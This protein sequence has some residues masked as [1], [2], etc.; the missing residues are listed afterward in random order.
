[1]A[2]VESAAAYLGMQV[3]DT[4][5]GQIIQTGTA[6]GRA[7]IKGDPERVA[8]QV[9]LAR[10][11]RRFA[12]VY[13][14]WH[15]SLFDASFLERE[16]APILARA[17]GR[18]DDASAA[19][20][21]A[22][23][24][25]QIGGETGERHREELEP[26]SALFLQAWREELEQQEV[27]R[28]VL[29]SQALERGADASEAVVQE[30]AALRVELADALGSLE[31]TILNRRRPDLAL[32]LDW[33][34]RDA[35]RRPSDFVG[36]EW[37]FEDLED[38]ARRHGRGYIHVVAEAGLGK[39]SLALETAR[40]LRA[41]AF[42]YRA[43][44]GRT[45]PAKCL[46]H[47]AVQLIAEHRLD[48][49]ELPLL[50]GSDSGFLVRILGELPLT[51]P[52]W[53]VIDALDEAEGALGAGANPSL[54][55]PDLPAGVF[56]LLTHR[57]EPLDLEVE[58][59]VGQ[60]TLRFRPGDA[61][62]E[63]DIRRYV[64]GRLGDPLIAAAVAR[65][66]HPAGG[67][68]I[69]ERLVTASEGNFK[70]LEYVFADI[71]SADA[72]FDL[73]VPPQGLDGYYRS[74]WKTMIERAGS[75]WDEIDLPLIEMLAVAGEA[76]TPEWLTDVTGLSKLQVR[77][78]LRR[79]Q[80]F[81]HQPDPENW[82][83]VHESFRDFLATT[84]D[85]DLPTAH[86]TLADLCLENPDDDYALAHT[87]V[88]LR[89]AERIAAL[90]ALVDGPSWQMAKLAADPSGAALLADITNAWDA[91]AEADRAA[92]RAER[93]PPWLLAEVVCAVRTAE[94]RSISGRVPAAL[95]ARLLED[96]V[97]SADEALAAAQLVPDPSERVA[98]LAAIAPHLPSGLRWR[99]ITRALD[100]AEGSGRG[101]EPLLRAIARIA[102][103]LTV[104]HRSSALQRALALSSA[105]VTILRD[106]LTPEDHAIV[107]AAL[108]KPTGIPAWDAHRIADLAPVLSP[109]DVRDALD[110]LD[111]LLPD[112]RIWAQALALAARPGGPAHD[113]V[114]ECVDEIERTLDHESRVEALEALAPWMPDDVV[115]DLFRSTARRRGG[116]YERGRV[117]EVLAPHLPDDCITGAIRIVA[118]I[119]EE[120]FLRRDALCALAA[121]SAEHVEAILAVAERTDDDLMAVTAVARIASTAAVG[122]HR[123]VTALERT[124]SI[125]FEGD[126]LDALVELVPVIADAAV[127]DAI[128]AAE[129][130]TDPTLR[131][132]ALAAVA[133]HVGRDRRKLLDAALQAVAATRH[134][135]DRRTAMTEL[136]P[137][138]PRDVLDRAVDIMTAPEPQI[139]ANVLAPIAGHLPPEQ[140]PAGARATLDAI[141]RTS[142]YYE[143]VRAF[144]ALAPSLPDDCLD[145]A[146]GVARA[147]I[148]YAAQAYS[149]TAL[150]PRVPSEDR[151]AILDEALRAAW[152][153][154]D[155]YDRA[156]ALEPLVATASD[157]IAIVDEG[158][159]C[160]RDFE[161]LGSAEMI[162][163]F[164]PHMTP[165][166]RAQA[167]AIVETYDVE[168]SKSRAR[169]A[170]LVHEPDA[171]TRA[172]TIVEPLS[173][174]ER[175]EALTTIVRRGVEDRA[176][177]RQAI[178]DV[179]RIGNHRK[180][181]RAVAALAPCLQPHEAQDA[182]RRVDDI[183]DAVPRARAVAALAVAAGVDVATLV[184]AETDPT[185]RTWLLAVMGDAPLPAILA[186]L[187][188]I[189]TTGDRATALTALASRRSG[190]TPLE[191]WHHALDDLLRG[192][193][194]AGPRAL[195]EAAAELGPLVALLSEP[196]TSP[197]GRPDRSRGDGAAHNRTRA[198][199]P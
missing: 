185:A 133:S 119:D 169:A 197:S 179:G 79:W 160:A 42:L 186:T 143:Q 168:A 103:A 92:L 4:I 146:L 180:R 196:A 2:I 24:A 101:V 151:Q 10:A 118:A 111:G 127:P 34:S 193:A 27:F 136:A 63:L 188:A 167:A 165:H 124:T 56:V 54:L 30:V 148:T 145:E 120:P 140:R 73:T 139:M 163:R 70:Y 134:E 195:E 117:I 166:Q 36:R 33:P 83:V 131:A 173:S 29:D 199:P 102:S 100:D 91:A 8:C 13:P 50:A 176:I 46:N 152:A 94:R 162:R 61:A 95:L 40:R 158:L 128:S 110:S 67:E 187:R 60:E 138:L 122:D 65:A 38:F 156:M 87:V 18:R 14:D 129:E 68:P 112:T 48:H 3:L 12:D 142:V 135:S 130:F 198:T 71:S 7:R 99:A 177:V 107:T 178:R 66:K 43:A 113:E 182:L 114:R 32:H 64:E 192:A 125:A 115:G 37:I 153:E 26:A 171:Q 6:K 181:A 78:A 172:I 194:A 109:D 47:L 19:E 57:P 82:H 132:R 44:D 175:A 191:D 25:R 62:Q 41:P 170:L 52:Q 147:C 150:A 5:V 126:R 16:G 189:P 23:W 184:K 28:G 141:A 144:A 98:A 190:D 9:A 183:H 88:H 80:R 58:P 89:G 105:K 77:R 84:D 108:A 69:A 164:A 157:P 75:T 72:E 20:L 35:V 51:Q 96:G 106:A 81:L 90:V 74:M 161:P 22:A 1:V 53:L 17:L 55:P 174:D 15:A 86:G 93:S 49:D 21:T 149:L 104:E 97:W 59:G 76:V 137:V 31:R 39:T 116:A 123:L 85:V 11:E 45:Q 154:P 159:R 121:R 155:P